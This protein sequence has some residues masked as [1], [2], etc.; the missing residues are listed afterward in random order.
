MAKTL[1]RRS[2]VVLQ[3]TWDITNVYPDITAWQADAQRL[4]TELPKLAAYAGT[5]GDA[6]ATLLAAL[7]HFEQ[8][9]VLMGRL[10]VYTSMNFDVD[11]TNQAAA[12]L[13]DQAIGLYARLGAT[14]A[15]VEPEL[16]ALEP[17]HLDGMI[18]AE[19]GLAVYRHLIENLRR[20]AAHVRSGEVEQL[21]AQAAEPL[22]AAYSSY[23]MLA[24]G[25]LQFADA[26]DAQGE[27]HTVTTSTIEELLHSP[28]RTLR[29]NAW[30][31]HQDG[32]LRFKNSI[33]SI[34]A[35]SVKG[36]VFNARARRYPSALDASLFA[37]NIPRTV[38]ENV[39][40]ACN[41]HLPIWHRYWAI[42]RRALGLEQIE[43]CDIFAPLGPTLRY[44][45]DEAVAIVTQAVAPLGATYQATAQTGL[46]TQR[47]VDVYPNQGK[48]SGAYSS[49]S[50]GTHPFI[51]LNFDG[52]LVNVST[53]AHELGHSMHTWYTQQHQPPIYADYAL[54]VAEVA[55][56][57]NQA[58][59]RGHLLAKQ[60]GRD[61]EIAILEEA[62]SNFHRYLFLMPILSQFE[63][64]V[65]DQAEKGQPL[66]ATGMNRVLSDLFAR[67]YGPAVKVD[68]ERDG[69]VWAQF[70]HLYANFYVYQYASG[71]AAANA[72]AVDVLRGD[73]EAQ[74]KYLRFLGAGSSVYPLDALQLAG[75]D[76]TSPEPLDRAFAVLEG[77]VSRLEAL[78]G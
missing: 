37:S 61:E 49:G 65:H 77:F 28:D 3:D 55:S 62:M 69:I 2:E 63:Q 74:A 47:W 36:D 13:R 26:L 59:L 17:A 12:A 33:G 57:F 10:F 42:R 24:E 35:G 39:I 19:P 52:T 14:T 56:N 22:S 21:L 30:C 64:H 66:T 38:Y 7:Q 43:A 8:A 29:Y 31:S 40:D 54:F 53:L 15:F 23:Q 6:P 1:P 34:Y 25:D 32:F 18:A 45:F 9:Q 48:T 72:L 76:M 71:I 73:Q 46:T 27:P 78:L 70:P 5:L 75:I 50:Y 60:P 67:G 11:T 44:S 41:R 4:E 20:R 51:L 68:P 58:L 16:L